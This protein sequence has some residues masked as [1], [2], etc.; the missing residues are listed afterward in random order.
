MVAFIDSF[1]PVIYK[2]T[3][4]CNECEL[5]V[6]NNRC[7]AFV[8][9]LI[10]STFLLSAVMFQKCSSN[11]KSS[12][13]DPRFNDFRQQLL[14]NYIM[15]FYSNHRPVELNAIVVGYLS[16]GDLLVFFFIAIQ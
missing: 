1:F 15:Q 6:S 14:S 12:D 13:C 4:R 11:Y 8:I 16:N 7:V 9:Q 2:R 3:L 5:L 10:F